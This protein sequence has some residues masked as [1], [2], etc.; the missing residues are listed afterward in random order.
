MRLESL[1]PP[2]AEELLGSELLSV[3]AVRVHILASARNAWHSTSSRRYLPDAVMF[4][5]RLSARRAA[6]PRRKQGTYFT[7]QDTPAL[8]FDSLEGT[9][10]IADFHPD[11]PFRTWGASEGWGLLA[12]DRLRV[13]TTI[14]QVVADFSADP[15]WD[16][17]WGWSGKDAD[18]VLMAVPTERDVLP[19]LG[20]ADFTQ[21][22]SYAQGTDWYL[23]W[24]DRPGRYSDTGVRSIVRRF[25][26]NSRD[27]WRDARS[28]V[29]HPI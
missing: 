27:S 22:T 19:R 4:S 5:D 23:G 16:S 9:I 21:S 6:E 28:R 17:A 3:S 7:V 13:G 1:R 12:L 26:A 24:V 25:Q 18:S 15:R 20:R 29:P 2:Q 11:V 10:V 14:G 8:R